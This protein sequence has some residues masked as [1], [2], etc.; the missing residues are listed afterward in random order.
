MRVLFAVLLFVP[1]I[2]LA[3]VPS[4]Y[5][6][7]GSMHG[8]PAELL[9]AVAVTEAAKPGED[10]PWPWTAN[11]AG[12]SHYYKNRMELY[13]ALLKLV[14]KER[15]LFDVGIM[16]INWHWNAHLF[17]GDLWYATDPYANVNAG[18]KFLSDLKRKSGSFNTAVAL[19]HVG[20][21][22]TPD[23]KR[24]AL[25]YCRQVQSNLPGVGDAH[26]E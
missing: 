1:A 13:T 11:I 24:R 25:E 8:V 21:M 19:Y 9:Y 20:S 18:A 15:F 6:R 4:V 7:Y 23:R 12:E 5:T 22:N 2:L 3:E 17:D 16:Q 14:E 10:H 26:H